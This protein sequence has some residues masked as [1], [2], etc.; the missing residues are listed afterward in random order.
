MNRAIPEDDISHATDNDPVL[1]PVVMHLEGEFL[2][3]L[4]CNP[5]D[6][7]EPRSLEFGVRTPGTVYLEV[8]VRDCITAVLKNLYEVPDALC[9]IHP[10]GKEGIARVDEDEILNADQCNLFPGGMHKITLRI[11][12]FRLS[13]I[14][15]AV[16]L[17]EIVPCAERPEVRPSGPEWHD[18]NAV[19]NLEEPIINRERGQFGV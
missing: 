11:D 19:G 9:H 15:M 8:I 10:A 2:S 7:V 1:A 13:R 5:L 17:L 16:V 4:D 3:R 12:K 6:P 18:C 14:A